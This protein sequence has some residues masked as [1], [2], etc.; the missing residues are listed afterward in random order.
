MHYTE[1]MAI[2]RALTFN[3]ADIE[4]TLQVALPGF[5]MSDLSRGPHE[6]D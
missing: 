6:T 2:C 3:S 5:K 1:N 4:S